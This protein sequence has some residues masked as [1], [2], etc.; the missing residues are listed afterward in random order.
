MATGLSSS[1]NYYT[2]YSLKA[3]KGL[4]LYQRIKALSI[5]HYLQLPEKGHGLIHALEIFVESHFTK[6]KTGKWS[7]KSRCVRSCTTEYLQT[8]IFKKYKQ[9]QHIKTSS[10]ITEENVF[11]CNLEVP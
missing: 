8:G 7:Y 6:I 11:E 3:I 9:L 4:E 5:L 1:A 2:F 10:I